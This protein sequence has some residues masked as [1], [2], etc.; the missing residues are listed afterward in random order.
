MLPKPNELA[1][2]G[3]LSEMQIL[4]PH[5]RHPELKTLRERINKSVLTNLLGN[6]DAYTFNDLEVISPD[7]HWGL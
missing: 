4:R 7:P 3:N 1:S 5:S 2:P 6:S